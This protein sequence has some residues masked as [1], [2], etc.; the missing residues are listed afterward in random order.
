VTLPISSGFIRQ[1]RGTKPGFETLSFGTKPGRGKII[2]IS[3]LNSHFVKHSK[4]SEC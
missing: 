3:K 1:K 2:M 4:W